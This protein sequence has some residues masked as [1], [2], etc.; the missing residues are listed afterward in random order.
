MSDYVQPV[1]EADPNASYKDRNTGAGIPGSKVPALAIEMPQ[2]EIR[3]VV[4]SVGLV[5]N[6]TDP[7]QLNAAIDAKIALAI[8]SGESPLDDLLALLRTKIFAYPEILTSDGKIPCLS[9]STGNFRVPLGYTFRH[10]GVFDVTTVQSD[11][12][13]SAN[14]IYHCFWDP[15]DG[16]QFKDL[17]DISYNPTSAPE[18]SVIFQSGYD[19]MLICRVVTDASNVLTI[20]NLVNRDRLSLSQIMTA[21][22]L[23]AA[24]AQE[25]RCAV[26]LTLN[27]ARQPLQKAYSRVYIPLNEFQA[28]RDEILY[29]SLAEYPGTRISELPATR[30]SMS[31]AYL[32][33]G[34]S[35]LPELYASVAA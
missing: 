5:P 13:T 11:F 16:V 17:A 2:R 33:D 22:D 34:L 30:Y 26:S 28:D 14:K 3:T 23:T 15:T 25:A 21:T 32:V 18:T 31:F 24:G 35:A 20:T 9:P 12:A 29:A 1:G 8:G 7:T 10:R 19:R 4:T 27:W 6:K